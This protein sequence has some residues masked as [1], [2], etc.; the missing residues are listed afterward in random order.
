MSLYQNLYYM[1]LV[2]GMSGLFS[3]ALAAL[4]FAV[5]PNQGAPWLPDLV[6]AGI[7]G[8]MIGGL[9]VGFSDHWAGNRVMPRWILSGT[10]IGLVAGLSAGLLEI[11]ITNNLADSSP[12]LT[13]VIAWMLAG[14]M[15][16]LGLGLRWVRVNRARVAHAV[17][18][19][20]LGGTL[21]GLIFAS[22]GSSV[23]DLSQA[24]G[25]VFIGVGICFG[26]TVAPMLLRDAVLEFVSSGDPVAQ[27]KFGPPKHKQWEIQHGDS[28]VLGSQSQDFSHTRYRP[29]IE[30]FIPDSGVAPRHAIL[31]G[32]EGRFF[33]ARHPEAADHAAI[34]RFRLRVRGRTVV[35][36]QELHGE[37]DILLGKTALKFV[38]R[39]E[40]A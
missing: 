32:R 36:T 24:L 28:Y 6:A 16:G 13:R 1:S 38:A 2:G 21:G 40:G 9:T 18:G 3:W 4:V 33:I 34:A 27:Y 22:L 17:V 37:D 5:L 31:F 23:P 15:I 26:V 39:R 7:L 12:V 14:S 25:F 35:R 30:I 10:L 11:P 8:A 20:L 19:G 29:D